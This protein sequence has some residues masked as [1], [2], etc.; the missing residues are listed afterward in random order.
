MQALQSRHPLPTSSQRATADSS[1][2]RSAEQSQESQQWY[3]ALKTLATTSTRQVLAASQL[4]QKQHMHST[5]Y[6]SRLRSQAV[7]SMLST[8]MAT[9]RRPW[10]QLLQ[11]SHS[12]TTHSSR[13]QSSHSHGQELS[14]VEQILRRV[15]SQ[16][17]SLSSSNPYR[18][19]NDMSASS[20]RM[21]PICLL[22]F[23]IKLTTIN[24]V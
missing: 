12:Q 22:I 24:N 14:S 7:Q 18:S 10:S 6:P 4:Q 21:V 23:R 3:P 1:L 5:S 9:T 17:R 19:G 20:I 15:L 2:L 13:T 11:S 16:Q 8:R